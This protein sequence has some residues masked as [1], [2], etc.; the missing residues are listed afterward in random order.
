MGPTC[1][2]QPD[3]IEASEGSHRSWRGRRR[4]G[5][6]EEADWK[7]GSHCCRWG[8]IRGILKNDGLTHSCTGEAGLANHE[9]LQVA[10]GWNL[11]LQDYR[12]Q[13]LTFAMDVASSSEGTDVR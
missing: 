4:G 2:G 11:A 1:Q 9:V 10:R 13:I 12:H 7:S 6:T 8:W 5:G 3:R